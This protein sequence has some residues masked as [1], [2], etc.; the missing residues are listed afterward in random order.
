MRKI[1]KEE[2]V[3]IIEPIKISIGAILNKIRLLEKTNAEAREKARERKDIRKMR[4]RWSNWILF[5]IVL[6]V[7]C[8]IILIFLIG[9]GIFNFS[10]NY[11]IPA[12]IGE[13]IIKIFLL[14]VIIVKFLFNK[15]GLE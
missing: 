13:S 7:I 1:N 9:A 10:N 4:K 12:F 15:K 3:K 6:V 2:A 5:C 11:T 14:A 8:D